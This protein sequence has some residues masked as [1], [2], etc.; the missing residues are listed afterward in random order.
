M[1]IGTA[2]RHIIN[3]KEYMLIGAEVSIIVNM[4]TINMEQS[5]TSVR[6]NDPSTFKCYVS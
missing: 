3:Q 5:A 2:T 4:L 6:P 1:R